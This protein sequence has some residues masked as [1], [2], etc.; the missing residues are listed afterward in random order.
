MRHARVTVPRNQKPARTELALGALAIAMALGG[1]TLVVVD[2][3]TP[4]QT[5]LSVVGGAV[6]VGAIPVLFH[7]LPAQTR[8][9]Q[10]LAVVPEAARHAGKLVAGQ[11]R[12][13]TPMTGRQ[14]TAYGCFISGPFPLYMWQA[15]ASAFTIRCDDGTHI[16]VPAGPIVL[17][18][19]RLQRR[20][21]VPG[22]RVNRWLAAI[23]A[24][25]APNGQQGM[26]TDWLRCGAEVLLCD[27]DRVEVLSE[28]R[29]TADAGAP[30]RDSGHRRVECV[31]TPML[32]LVR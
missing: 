11:G 28:V 32:R 31:G 26:S 24:V 23:G 1:A 2:A 18:V 10:R 9:L 20:D 30:Y 8:T 7:W 6:A 22:R 15:Q 27:A 16:D 14:A 29:P 4:G 17:D 5:W 19:P 21:V 12:V 3:A 25:W 13:V